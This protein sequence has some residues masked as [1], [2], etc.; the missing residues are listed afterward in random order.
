M[1]V[2]IGMECNGRIREAFS[3]R[4]HYAV[5]CDLKPCATG[6]SSRHIVGDVFEVIAKHPQ[7][8]F[9]LAILHPDCTYLS[10]S[11]FHW[12]Y[13]DPLEYPNTLCGAPRLAAVELAVATFKRCAALPIARKVIEN[14]IGI[15][16]TRYR[17]PNQIIQPYEFGDDASKK[18]GL[19]L[20]NVPPL[21]ALGPRF[22]GRLVEWPRGSGR[23]VERWSNQT[24]SG[25]NKLTPSESRAAERAITY[26]GWSEAFA[27]QW[28]T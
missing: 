7:G 19:W 13:R 10:V 11:G 18:T 14:P 20:Y 4:G 17:R 5:S 25:Q 1:R 9:D 28:G 24:D 2:F 27:S 3:R 16:N 22:P 15:I 6:E 12:C 21:L 23:V 26:N 8:F